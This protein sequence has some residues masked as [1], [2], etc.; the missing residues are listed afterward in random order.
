MKRFVALF[1]VLVCAATML[2][3][4]QEQTAPTE[5]PDVVEN[6][7]IQIGDVT[8]TGATVTIT[9]TNETPFIYGEWYKI[10]RKTDQGWQDVAPVIKDSTFTAIGYFP[11]GNGQVKFTIDWQWLYGQLPSGTYRLWKEVGTQKICAQF[12]I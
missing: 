5:Q 1:L 12:T 3:G 10:Q 7:T 4:C 2:A 11:N 8:P 6:V 9:D